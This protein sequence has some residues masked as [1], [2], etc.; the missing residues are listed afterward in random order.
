MINLSTH[1]AKFL[2][3]NNIMLLLTYLLMIKNRRS[4][5][6][7]SF[8]LGKNPLMKHQINPNRLTH[9]PILNPIKM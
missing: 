6:L 8:Q 5:Q 9:L 2:S 1:Q 3:L 7:Q 4:I